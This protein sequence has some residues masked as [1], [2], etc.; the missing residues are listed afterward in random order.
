[1]AII[2][3]PK[4]PQGLMRALGPGA[5]G[6]KSS[7]ENLIGDEPT[8]GNFEDEKTSK[9]LSLRDTINL[10]KK[11]QEQSGFSKKDTFKFLETFTFSLQN[12]L[13]KSVGGLTSTIAPKIRNELVQITKLLD[14]GSL[15]DQQ[16]AFLK[17]DELEKK[18]NVNLKKIVEKF[19]LSID[20]FDDA[21]EKYSTELQ[22][23]NKNIREKQENLKEQGVFTRADK[24]GNLRIID[25]QLEDKIILQKQKFLDRLKKENEERLKDFQS[26]KILQKDKEKVE[27]TIIKQSE[28]ISKLQEGLESRK[29]QSGFTQRQENKVGP[30]GK[31]GEIYRQF[32]PT[33]LQEFVDV[34]GA[35]LGGIG[36]FVGSFL[37][38]IAR[39][40]L[41]KVFDKTIK[42]FNNLFSDLGKGL[43]D[44]VK[45]NILNP[46]ADIGK[47]MFAQAKSFVSKIIGKKDDS[48]GIG[49]GLSQMAGGKTASGLTNVVKSGGGS[50]LGGAARLAPLALG[51]G[52]AA[53][54]GA[55]AGGAAAGGAAAGGGMLAGLGALALNPITLGILGIGG[56]AYGGYKAYQSYK[57]SKAMTD[58]EKQA[59]MLKDEES[60]DFA[61]SETG[62][63]YDD[64]RRKEIE[65]LE[66]ITPF[67]E[68]Y[69][70]GDINLNEKTG[71]YDFA[72]NAQSNLKE[73][74]EKQRLTKATKDME[75][76]KN[77]VAILNNQPTINNRTQQTTVTQP[78]YN[79]I[80][81]TFNILHGPSKL[82]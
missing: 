56:L 13:T 61:Y 16:L 32:T 28:R 11:I 73:E 17:I 57:K 70:G 72:A 12:S 65:K 8:N 22:E 43:M 79:N 40:K 25:T 52:A 81:P 33:I 50:A 34:L 37:P 55:A 44:S 5:M 64:N 63:Q 24:E 3:D 62:L 1:M 19:G 26:G 23:Q 36:T 42:V 47:S 80:D 48:S 49:V 69:L 31:L 45:K 59:E 14:T 18:F 20:D 9:K 46:L 60:R 7:E 10:V 58:E 51:G 78:F 66:K 75:E 68:K 21:V 82:I 71:R 76:D 2:K 4:D 29:Q 41:G 38:P 53:A 27:R 77:N 67:S 39:E 35:T 30:M 54:G 74:L 15:K 6:M